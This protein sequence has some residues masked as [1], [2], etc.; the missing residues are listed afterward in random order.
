MAQ[1]KQRISA[2]SPEVSSAPLPRGRSSSTTHPTPGYGSPRSPAA[3]A[4]APHLCIVDILASQHTP[5][6]LSAS[7]TFLVQRAQITPENPRVSEREF[8]V[9]GFCGDERAG[10]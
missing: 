1:H 3:P 8:S 2:A 5:P 4:R 10:F 7:L 9:A 6:T